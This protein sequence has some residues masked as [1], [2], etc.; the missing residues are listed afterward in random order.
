MPPNE[1]SGPH[2]TKKVGVVSVL[3]LLVALGAWLFPVQSP[4]TP[5]G[6]NGGGHSQSGR[7]DDPIIKTPPPP[8]R[9]NVETLELIEGQSASVFNQTASLNYRGRRDGGAFAYVE[10]EGQRQ[11]VIFRRG[12]PTQIGPVRI[13]L[14]EFSTMK[15]VTGYPLPGAVFDV[16]VTQ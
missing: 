6:S 1:S 9:R 12:Q 16:Q 8:P 4:S 15:T 5:G 2:N 7:E 13:T 3:S 14:R 10:V 11:T